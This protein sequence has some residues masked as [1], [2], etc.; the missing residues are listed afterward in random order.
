MGMCKG[1]GTQVGLLPCLHLKKVG[2]I[3][4]ERLRGDDGAAARVLRQP[5]GHIQYHSIQDQYGLTLRL[6]GSLQVMYIVVFWQ[7]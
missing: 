1:H 4:V 6:V 5:I 3:Q 2:T 7:D